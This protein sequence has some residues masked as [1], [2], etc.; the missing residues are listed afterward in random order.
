MADTP[1]QHISVEDL[2]IALQTNPSESIQLIDVREP[3]EVETAAIPGFINLPLSQYEYWAQE[4]HTHLDTEKETLVICH[5]G[6]RS[7]QMCYW[8]N[9]QGFSNVKNIIGGIDAYSLAIDSSIPRY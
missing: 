8:L 7:A 6:I 3:Q 5:H 4:I 2:A 1:F 9:Q